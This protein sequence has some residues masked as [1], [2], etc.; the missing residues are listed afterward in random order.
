MAKVQ[1]N[2]PN[3]VNGV[4]QQAIALRLPSQAASSVNF[5]PT[6]VD[7][8]S[9]RPRTD[10]LA[11]LDANVAADNVFTHIYV[12][13]GQE[14]YIALFYIDG[15]IRV[16]DFQGNEQTVNYESGSQDY[17]TAGTRPYYR[18]LRALT[19]ADYT[20]IV[21]RDVTV[22]ARS[23]IKPTRLPEAMFYVQ[24]GN[25]SKHYSITVNGA[26][27]A[28]YGTPDSGDASHEP[29]V[30][31]AYI[32]SQLYS[33][34]TGLVGPNWAKG[35]YGNVVYVRADNG[36]DFTCKM[37]DG[38]GGRASKAVHNTVQHF[39]DLPTDG[40]NGFTIKVTGSTGTQADDYW[41]EL[42]DGIWNE[43][44]K[45]GSRLGLD[46]TTMPH[47]LVRQEDG[48]FLFKAIVWADRKA[49]S[50]DTIKDPS[51]V[52]QKIDD[53][54]FFRNRLGFLTEQ[55]ICMSNSG[56]FYNFYRPTLTTTLD[57]DPIDVA[58]SHTK[59]SLLKHAAILQGELLLFSAQTQFKL[60]GNDLLTPK[61]VSAL[62]LMEYIAAEN[63][64]PVPSASNCYFVA[65]Q[66]GY[67]QLYEMFLDKARETGDAQTTTSHVP[68]YVPAGV[69]NMIA[70]PD[71]NLIFLTTR[72]D[73]AN[74]YVYKYHFQGQEKVQSAWQTW[75]FPN[76]D[77]VLAMTFD[78][79]GS[80]ILALLRQNGIS[81]ER[82]RGEQRINDAP[83]K[84]QVA[85][86]MYHKLPGSAWTYD[87][88]TD[89]STITIPY[90][91]P[92]GM[93][94]VS[95]FGGSRPVGV[96]RSPENAN[97]DGTVKDRDIVLKGD[98]RGQP[99]IVGVPY[100]SRHRL[101]PFFYSAPDQGGKKT[102]QTNGRTQVYD[103]EL[104][105]STT[106]YFRV[107][108]TPEGRATRTYTYNA[109]RLDASTS[110]FGGL[111][112][113]DGHISFPV[114]SRNDR[115]TIDLVNDSWLPST[116]SMGQWRG[117][118]TPSVREQ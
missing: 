22:A 78:G 52:T 37:N 90:D 47:A 107:E 24:A 74:L 61:S 32:A 55:N 112:I 35:L 21:N 7:G 42:Q 56:D 2:I 59:V 44:V 77:R 102:V 43:T 23:T 36:V 41:V 96:D 6:V 31:T 70:S 4:S 73:P 29:Y 58:C 12:R 8:L 28:D 111:A 87:A 20:F 85:L 64:R 88:P 114:L 100:E 98:W 68:F 48:T 33:A 15:T 91:Q 92:R 67:A 50:D 9:K 54:F 5:Y 69:D 17:L 51:F 82:M 113:L 115:V 95:D 40:P 57:T 93:I 53:V 71:L 117:T 83:L 65:E 118:F 1:G 60:K 30:D 49:G 13:D 76:A 39:S 45:P 101:S 99:I 108:V 26:V 34:A 80:V 16:W 94:V 11:T 109:R 19:I 105:Y 116:F 84:F 79:K 3:F 103:C 62:P 14:Q 97:L 72:S 104:F 110:T 81:L 86:D 66:D 38:Y 27:A 10:W 106:G 46:K 63:V 18:R 75:K 89:R 25:Y